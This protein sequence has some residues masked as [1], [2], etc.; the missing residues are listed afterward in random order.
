VIV[1]V[2][3]DGAVDVRATFVADGDEP[4]H[5]SLAATSRCVD[6]VDDKGGPHV[7]GA[8][9]DHVHVDVAVD[10]SAQKCRAA[11]TPT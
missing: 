1:Y 4:R 3:A 7:H 2:V 5:R 11:E 10:A 8:V 9:F 6:R